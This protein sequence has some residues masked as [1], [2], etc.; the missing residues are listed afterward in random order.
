[1]NANQ[2]AFPVRTMCRALDVS[3]RGFYDW[4]VRAPSQSKLNDAVLLERIGTI[5]ADSDGTGCGT[6]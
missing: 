2:A 5:H 4:L 6:V 3:P 1:M